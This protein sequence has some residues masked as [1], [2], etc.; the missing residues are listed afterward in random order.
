VVVNFHS[1]T[2]N[3]FVHLADTKS[4]G[5]SRKSKLIEAMAANFEK[6]GPGILQLIFCTF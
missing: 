6:N 4:P 2:N 3:C 1:H 5:R